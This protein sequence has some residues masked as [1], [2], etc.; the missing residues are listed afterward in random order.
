M[1]DC[2]GITSLPAAFGR[3]SS[4]ERLDLGKSFRLELLPHDLGSLR[5]LQQ[6]GLHS[7]RALV[8]WPG[9]FTRL[10]SLKRL[11]LSKCD[12][13]FISSLPAAY[14]SLPGVDD[15]NCKI[16]LEDNEREGVNPISLDG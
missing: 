4:L 11:A 5:C 13:A 2:H 14:A 15:S 6:L 9:S 7:C 8:S 16:D 1:Y 10:T 3:L 12:P